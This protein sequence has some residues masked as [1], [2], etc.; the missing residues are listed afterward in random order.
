MQSSISHAAGFL[1]VVA[2]YATCGSDW[3]G[4]VVHTAG[5]DMIPFA[6]A[7]HEPTRPTLP[8]HRPLLLLLLRPAPS[9][10]KQELPIQPPPRA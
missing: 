3:E 4:G 2:S 7:T 5:A 8:R 6:I 9:V 1:P 10:P